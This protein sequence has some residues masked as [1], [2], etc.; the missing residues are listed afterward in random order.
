MSRRQRSTHVRAKVVDRQISAVG[1]KKNRDHLVTEL[2]GF[3][4]AGS[5]VADFADRFECRLHFF[6]ILI[7]V[8][9]STEV[10]IN[11]SRYCRSDL[12]FVLNW[13]LEK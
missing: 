2:E 11:F 12:I 9:F 1:F 5:D 3:T 6:S 13:L 4:G 8:S 10:K 7:R